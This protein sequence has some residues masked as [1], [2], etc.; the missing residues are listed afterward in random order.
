MGPS[1]KLRFDRVATARRSDASRFSIPVAL[2]P[3]IE[4]VPA[5]AGVPCLKPSLY[6]CEAKRVRVLDY[7]VKDICVSTIFLPS[8]MVVLFASHLVPHK[9]LKLDI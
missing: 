6:S 9:N 1:S 2:P 8:I 5:G 3:A 4:S 7:V